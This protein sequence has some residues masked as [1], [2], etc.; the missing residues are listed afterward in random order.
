MYKCFIY[1]LKYNHDRS[2]ML[3]KKHTVSSQ[4][5]SRVCSFCQGR[6]ICNRVSWFI[7]LSGDNDKG[8]GRTLT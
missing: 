7:H 4:Q 6:W 8:C 1:D 5:L 2:R 3:V